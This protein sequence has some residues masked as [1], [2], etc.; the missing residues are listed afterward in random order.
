MNV[1]MMPTTSSLRSAERLSH[2][3][4]A[5]G[6]GGGGCCDLPFEAEPLRGA[7][8]FLDEMILPA[9]FVFFLGGVD[10]FK[11]GMNL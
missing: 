10:G 11:R 6:G 4:N 1:R 7:S 5:G 9:G 8:P 2:H 3:E